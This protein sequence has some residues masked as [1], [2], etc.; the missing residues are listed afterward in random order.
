[1]PG[2]AKAPTVPAWAVDGLRGEDSLEMKVR[3]LL[4]ERRQ[5]IGYKPELAVA[6]VGSQ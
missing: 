4:A 5:L 2:R 3:A 6:V 1:M